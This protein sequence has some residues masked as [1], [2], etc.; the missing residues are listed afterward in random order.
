MTRRRIL[1]LGIVIT[2]V[3]VLGAGWSYIRSSD[4]GMAATSAANVTQAEGNDRVRLLQARLRQAPDDWQ[5]WS[6]LAVA[7]LERGRVT[8][9]P[10]WYPRAEG[11]IQRSLAIRPDANLDA[12]VAGSYLAAARHDFGAALEWAERAQAIGP[13]SAEVQGVLGDALVELGRY[14]EG[15]AAFQRM[16]DRKP[17]FSSYARISYARELQG[18]VEGAV[19]AMDAARKAASSAADAAFA[20]FQLGE[21]YWSQGRAEEAEVR[22]RRASVLDEEFLP[23]QAALARARAAAGDVD[24]AA[25]SYERIIGKVP[26]PQYV[27]ELADLAAAR[28]DT[29][30]RK[31]Q[32]ELIGAQFELL[33]ANGVSADLELALFSAD[34]G[35]ELDKGLAAAEAGW[36]RRKSVHAAD[37]L[38][39]QLYAHGRP[40]EALPLADQALRLGTRSALFHYH[41]GKIR[42]ALGQAEA[43]QAD[44]RE[45]VEINPKFSLLHE[46]EARRLLGG[47]SA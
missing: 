27:A 3:G 17:N 2:F 7:Y 39:W 33:R 18:D 30:L 4:G 29:A 22:F 21:L 32:I 15:F 6:S 11:S 40:E 47:T 5:A 36:A 25:V 9:D 45:A 19:A 41:R 24:E 37:A 43:G 1:V 23:P 8:A 14:D 34:H 38:A 42:L 10:S 16:V 44:L 31:S 13:E 28:G 12:T 20:E 26:A 46:A 35:T